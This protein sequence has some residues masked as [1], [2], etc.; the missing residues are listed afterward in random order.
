MAR[1]TF[2]LSFVLL[3]GIACFSGCETLA[4]RKKASAEKEETK[5]EIATGDVH[6]IKAEGAKAFHPGNRRPGLLSDEAREI[7]GHFNIQ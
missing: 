6:S 2:R 1:H 3:M 7:E 5:D 4:H